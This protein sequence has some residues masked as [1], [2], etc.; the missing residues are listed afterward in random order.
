[1]TINIRKGYLN[2]YLCIFIIFMR[3]HCGAY[4]DIY[5]S[6]GQG[7]EDEGTASIYTANDTSEYV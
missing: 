1:M 6:L 4:R 5:Q 2:I 7:Y 3:P